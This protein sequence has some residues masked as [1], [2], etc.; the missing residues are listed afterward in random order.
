ME[1]QGGVIQDA[2]DLKFRTLKYMIMNWDSCIR[3]SIH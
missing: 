1:D 3:Q 2:M